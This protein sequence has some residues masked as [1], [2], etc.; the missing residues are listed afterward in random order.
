ME[1][2]VVSDKQGEI[3]VRKVG[4]RPA[5]PVVAAP[6]SPNEP[7]APGPPCGGA[8]E[9]SPPTPLLIRSPP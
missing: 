8:S 9:R 3:I 6:P 2:F 7:P 1:N 5:A 4:R